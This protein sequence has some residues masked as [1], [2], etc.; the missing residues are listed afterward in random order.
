MVE[1]AS[2]MVPLGT[3]MPSFSLPAIAG[4]LWTPSEG[5]KGTLVVFMCNHCPFVIHIAETLCL[6]HRI[7]KE[8]NIEMVGINSNDIEA[9]P[10]DT[11]EKMAETAK[12]YGWQFPYVFDATQE[13]ATQFSATCTPDTFLYNSEKKLIYRGQFDDSRPHSGEST[14]IDLIQALEA[15]TSNLPAQESQKP[16]IGCNIKWK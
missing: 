10:E 6:V 5:S 8:K 14:G 3:T 9:Y 4:G 12:Y 11:P 1:T 16:A 7:S 13:V 15:L 2:S